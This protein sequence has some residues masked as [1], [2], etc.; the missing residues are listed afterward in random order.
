MEHIFQLN[1]NYLKLFWKLVKFIQQ[2]TW[3]SAKQCEME[4]NGTKHTIYIPQRQNQLK[5]FFYFFFYYYLSHL[6]HLTALD[7]KCSQLDAV[8]TTITL[9][10]TC[11]SSCHTL[12]LDS[13][14]NL[15]RIK[16]RSC[17]IF[18]AAT[19]KRQK[20]ARSKVKRTG[21]FHFLQQIQCT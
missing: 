11:R 20:L 21:T 19:V 3:N 1:A 4:W 2:F 5:T 9:P 17:N 10:A 13:Q 8:T 6:H 12:F 18:D 7:Y 15:W 16:S 14:K